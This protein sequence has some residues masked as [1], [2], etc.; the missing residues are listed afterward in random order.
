MKNITRLNA[1]LLLKYILIFS[2]FILNSPL[3]KTGSVVEFKKK[4]LATLK[5]LVFVFNDFY[6]KIFNLI[7]KAH[8]KFFKIY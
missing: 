5:W 2:S 6:L 3:S 4:I 1:D 8:L 7:D